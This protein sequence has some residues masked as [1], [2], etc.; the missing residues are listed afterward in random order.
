M[1]DKMYRVGA[2]GAGRKGTEHARAYNLNPRAE[3]VAV[4]DPDPE[5]LELFTRRFGVPGY[6]DYSEMLRKENLDI[7]SAIL[8]V[9][10]NSKVVIECARAG[11]PA[12]CCE[13]PMSATLADADRIVEECRA[14]GV[15]L[16]CGDLERNH[17]FYWKAK[18]LIDSGAIGKV[19]SISFMQGSGTQLSGGGCQVFGLI[20]LFAGDV[21]VEFVTGWVAQDPWSDYDQG[22]AGYI[23]FVNGVE[24]FVHRQDTGKSG[25]E[26]L[27]DKGVFGSDGQFLHLYASPENPPN[28]YEARRLSEVEGVFS[29]TETIHQGFGIVDAEGWEQPGGRQLSTV[30]SMIDALDHDIEPRGNGEN[31]RAVLETAIAIRESHRRGHAPVTLPLADRD[32]R[33]IPVPSRMY[34][35]REVH[36]REW[37]A[38]QMARFKR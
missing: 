14:R 10:A 18:S 4:A 31:G 35:K 11:V 9:S 15:K 16:G 32:L 12:I 3:V 20:R 23:R 36:G 7:V 1:T 37:Y 38:Q 2:I 21:D 26:V 5:N 33:L 28:W 17:H 29:E 19:S 25:F 8:P 22:G 6:S 24:A 30:Q 13:K 34:N 27:G